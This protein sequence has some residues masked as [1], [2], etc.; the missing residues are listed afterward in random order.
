[1]TKYIVWVI[2]LALT[3]CV[4]YDRLVYL[5]AKSDRLYDPYAIRN[6]KIRSFDI[7]SIELNSLEQNTSRYFNETFSEQNQRQQANTSIFYITGYIVSDSGYVDLPLVGQMKVAG[8]TTREIQSLVE[9]NLQE[10]IKF[11]SVSVKLVNFRVSVFGEV[12]RPGVQYI[13]EE[14]YTLLQAI[15]QAGNLTDFGD[16]EQIKLLRETNEGVQTVHLDLTDPNIVSSEYFF[17]QPN[18]AI[19]VEPQRARAFT[20]NSRIVSISFSVISLGLA[21]INLIN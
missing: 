13:Y 2:L 6:Y 15:A 16:S 1:M 4:K 20:L 7:L 17:L 11:P 8:L 9:Q 18:D 3:S 21:I 12:A 14:K 5:D 19:Y 10:Y